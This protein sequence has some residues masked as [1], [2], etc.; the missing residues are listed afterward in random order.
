MNAP[1]DNCPFRRANHHTFAL[2]LERRKEIAAS[3]RAEQVFPCH[4]TT[5]YFEDEDGEGDLRGT[6]R[7]HFCAGALAVMDNDPELSK[8]G[9]CRFSMG[10]RIHAMFGRFQPDELR[11]H[12]LVF[13]SLDEWITTP[14]E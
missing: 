6:A 5:E 3:L 8:L 13:G 11:G 14:S 9:G 4:K 7:S 12:D 2:S 10:A 1:C